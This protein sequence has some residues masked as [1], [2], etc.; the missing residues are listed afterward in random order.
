MNVLL[1]IHSVLR[2]IIVIVGLVVAAKSAYGWLAKAKFGPADRGLMSA[3]VGLLDLQLLLGAG[4]LFALEGGVTGFRMEHATTMLLAVA[5][6]HF[7]MRWRKAPDGIRFR[8]NF[9][10]II[11]VFLFIVA[12]VSRLPQGWFG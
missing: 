4:L 12:G 10:V 5:A 3:F 7:S 6:G 9:I 11:V 8:N 2:W 1:D